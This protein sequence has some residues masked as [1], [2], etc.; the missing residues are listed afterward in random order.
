MKKISVLIFGLIVLSACDQ[1]STSSDQEK[2]EAF[3]KLKRI[4]SEDKTRVERIRAEYDRR[5]AL[6]KA[7]SS[8]DLLDVAEVEA[9]LEEV[10]KELLI[11]RYF[12]KYLQEKVTDKGV[13]NYYSENVDRY[14][15]RRVKVSHILFRTNSRMSQE[16]RQA[17]S[18][19]ASEAYSRISSNEDF[20]VVA[21]E[22]SED[23]VSAEQGGSLGWINEG[24]ISDSF[25]NKV[26]AMKAGDVSEPFLTDYG[27][28]IVKV[29]E[30]PQDVTQPLSALKGDIRYQLRTK[31]KRAETQRLLESVGYKA[32]APSGDKS[33]SEN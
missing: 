15:S 20:A 3:L 4:S 14:K 26:F 2:F 7:I 32:S 13:Q 31:S 5:A 6:A 21:K 11:S 22:I 29:E 24:A 17:V 27:F 23:R 18:T 16:E 8:T 33:V 1:S 25:S 10:R 9:E 30:E 12:E 28:H 19:K